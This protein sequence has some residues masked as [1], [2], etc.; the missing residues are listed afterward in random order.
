MQITVNGEARKCGD[1]ASV[2]DLLRDMGVNP[3]RAA[4]L[5]NDRVVPRSERSSLKLRDA[6]RVEILVFAGGG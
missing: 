4:V 3:E 5:V 1:G 6:D 2:E